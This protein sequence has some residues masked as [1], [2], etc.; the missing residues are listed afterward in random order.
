MA[1]MAVEVRLE[2]LSPFKER[3]I[4]HL[5]LA[6]KQGWRLKRYAIVADGRVFDEGIASAATDEALRRL[7]EAGSL[8][9]AT[10]NHGIGFQIIHFAETA[11]VSPVF[12]W[13]WGSV[14]ARLG[15]IKAHW[16]SPT[17]FNDGVSEVVGC[18]WEMNVVQHETA[19]WTSSMLGQ[20]APPLLR[21]STYLEDY[22]Q[23]ACA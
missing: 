7:P 4:L 2:H 3:D 19:A 20:T 21:L 14:L 22:V 8:E 11:V 16:D 17:A 10:G 9:N 23:L 12:Y 5:E 6:H 18:I 13:Q 15:Q 1:V